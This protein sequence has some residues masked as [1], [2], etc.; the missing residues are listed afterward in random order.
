MATDAV[1][2][3]TFR[4]RRKVEL[5]RLRSIEKAWLRECARKAAARAKSKKPMKSK[6]GAAYDGTTP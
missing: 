4:Q 3:V 2:H 5:E 1:R 6:E